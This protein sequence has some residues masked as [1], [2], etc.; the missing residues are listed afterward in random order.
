LQLCCN[1]KVSSTR[2]LEGTEGQGLEK[3]DEKEDEKDKKKMMIFRS[4]SS[5]ALDAAREIIVSWKELWEANP[6]LLAVCFDLEFCMATCLEHKTV[7]DSIRR[8]LSSGQPSPLL[9]VGGGPVADIQ[10]TQLS[11]SITSTIELHDAVKCTHIAPGQVVCCPHHYPRHWFVP[12][13]HGPSSTQKT[14][15]LSQTRTSSQI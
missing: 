2:R 6:L 11:C 10:T 4:S 8:I 13:V 7:L 9:L 3:K 12:Q 5:S 15:K 1:G 14:R